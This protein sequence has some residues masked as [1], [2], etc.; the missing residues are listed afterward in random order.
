MMKIAILFEGDIYHVRGE[1]SAIHN[2][3]KCMLKCEDITADAYNF[4]RY[5]DNLTC[6]IR[7]N[8][9]IDRPPVFD[10]DGIR[11]N[12]CYYKRS[13]LDFLTRSLSQY[14]TN[15]EVSRVKRFADRFRGYDLIYAH[16]LY[17]G[18]LAIQLKETFGMPSVVMWHGSSIHTMPFKNKTVFNLTKKV[19]ENVDFNF[20]V[21]SD[22]MNTAMKIT[23]RFKGDV[24]MNGVDTSIFRP[25]SINDRKRTKEKYDINVNQL[26]VA[27]VGNCLPVKNVNYLPVLFKRIHDE[28]NNVKFHI[29]GVGNFKFLFANTYLEVKYWGN[30]SQGEMPEIYNCMD[31]VVM[32]SINEGLPMTCLEATACGCDF[33]GARVGAIAEVVGIQNSIPHGKTFDEDFAQKCII[34]LKNRNRNMV[35]LPEKFYPQNIVNKE[36]EIMTQIVQYYGI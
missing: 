4:Q 34:K 20:F 32:P 1:F 31:L 36:I 21:S 29:V 30:R 27:Y 19:I 35:S 14:Q 8:K 15:V 11:Y 28:I 18:L 26:N 23:T 25:F 33:V 2:R 24:S 3:L 5:Y 9:P 6:F 12:C 22:L 16:S 13:Y 7:R 10:M 17:T